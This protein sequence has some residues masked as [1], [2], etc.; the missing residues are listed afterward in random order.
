M[1]ITRHA[2]VAVSTSAVVLPLTQYPGTKIQNRGSAS[3]F[4]GGDNTVTTSNGFE[5]VAGGVIQA[6][7]LEART[8]T[9]KDEDRLWAIA[10]SSQDVRLFNMARLERSNT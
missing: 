3:I 5:L 4:L 1:A 7:E 9:G 10:G 8:L 6:S 2:A